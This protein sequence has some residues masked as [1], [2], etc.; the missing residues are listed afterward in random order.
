VGGSGPES[1]SA[2][3]LCP[4]DT[5]SADRPGLLHSLLTVIAN[6]V[7][8]SPSAELEGVSSPPREPKA[9]FAT[10]LADRRGSLEM[11]PPIGYNGSTGCRLLPLDGGRLP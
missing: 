4:L 6:A 1:V 7:R 10:T 5:A 3:T 11:K 2:L 9:D 8:Q